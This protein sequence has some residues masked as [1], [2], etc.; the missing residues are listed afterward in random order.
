MGFGG[1][2]FNDA[3][4]ILDLGRSLIFRNRAAGGAG[5][6]GIGGGIYNLNEDE[7]EGLLHALVFANYA[8]TSDDNCFGC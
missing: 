5:G 7:T 3:D 6:Q 8:S 1:G 2:V 4:S